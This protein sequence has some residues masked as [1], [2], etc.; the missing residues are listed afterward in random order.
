MRGQCKGRSAG[1]FPGTADF[2]IGEMFVGLGFGMANVDAGLE[3]GEQRFE[4]G[5]RI[6]F[7]VNV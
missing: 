2:E 4:A 5:T 6:N 7:E 1:I 3:F